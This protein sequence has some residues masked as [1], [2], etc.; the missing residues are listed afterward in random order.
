MSTLTLEDLDRARRDPVVFAEVMVGKP[1]W[2]HQVE[3]ARSE[4]RYRIICAGR[5]AGKSALYAVLGLHQAFSV[6]GSKVLIVS[7]GELAAKRLF[8]EVALMARAPRLGGST[9][10]E[11][12][13]TLVLSNGSSIECVPASQK[14]V[15]S[16]EADLL[17][18]DE[19]GF[20]GQE[21]WESA[22]PVVVAR[23]G[24]RVLMA[25]TPWGGL[26]HFFRVLWKLGTSAPDAKVESWHW[27]SSVSPLVDQ[28]FLDDVRGRS[29]PHYFDREY[30][31]IWT[32]DAGAFFAADELE[33]ATS[34]EP[35]V[36]PGSEGSWSWGLVV[37][38]VDWA[39]R[40]DAQALA[41]VGRQVFPDDLGR[42]RWR[43]LW[44]EQHFGMSYDA[45]INRVVEAAGGFQSVV[46]A[47][48]T[49]GVGD[50][51]TAMLAQRMAATRRGAVAPV[52]TTARLK[53]NAF[54]LM[55]LLFQQ[56]RLQL[57]RDPDLLKQ[58]A[59]LEGTQLDGGGLRISVPETQG[60]DDLAMALCLAVTRLEAAEM[61]WA[62]PR[63]VTADDLDEELAGYR[64]VTW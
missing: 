6:P 49:N 48:E 28:E 36:A 46:L 26:T 58:L 24:S 47:S 41:V 33:A 23:P 2:P 54:G 59:A 19:A 56:G 62:A 34:G 18:V 4:A 1:L 10:D 42:P 13:S 55:R 57:P 31:A 64:V 5:R 7:A 16:A 15:R 32:D 39:S 8:A 53:E 38:G 21:I 40:R 22:E 14:A 27:P 45:W 11:T 17:I 3:V 12:T 9:V 52:Q 25:S 51:P 20:V 43:V 60:H 50:Y 37:G 30:L 63:L 35:M 29:A 61:G 44:C